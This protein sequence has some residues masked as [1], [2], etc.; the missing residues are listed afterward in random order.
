MVLP[1]SNSSQVG[2]SK[3]NKPDL[4]QKITFKSICISNLKFENQT[5]EATVS[6]SSKI[7]GRLTLNIQPKGRHNCLRQV[8]VGIKEVGPMET[9]LSERKIVGRRLEGFMSV[10]NQ[11]KVYETYCDYPKEFVIEA[12]KKPGLYELEVCLLE[13]VGE[14]IEDAGL[15]NGFFQLKEADK[16]KLQSPDVLDLLWNMNDHN[17]RIS[18]GIIRVI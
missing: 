3:E 17:C 2:F 6:P 13:F 1:V 4:A 5:N 8:L 11:M 9:I 14:P 15:V 12:P 18:L 16:E 7:Y 10:D